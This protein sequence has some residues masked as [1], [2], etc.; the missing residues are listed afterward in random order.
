MELISNRP[1]NTLTYFLGKARVVIISND[2]EVCR[3]PEVLNHVV[4]SSI[5][6]EIMIGLEKFVVPVRDKQSL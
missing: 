5:E 2:K 3:T 6:R 4:W 1:E